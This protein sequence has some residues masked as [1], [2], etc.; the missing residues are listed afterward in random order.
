[1][2]LME[3]THHRSPMIPQAV[4]EAAGDVLCEYIAL[5]L[6]LAVGALVSSVALAAGMITESSEMSMIGGAMM[7]SFLFGFALAQMSN[8]KGAKE[9]GLRW[10]TN[11]C[12][13]GPTGLF[14]A[15]H[16]QSSF[17]EMPQW[18]VAMIFSGI[19]GPLAVLLIPIGIPFIRRMFQLYIADKEE[20][21][22][23]VLNHPENQ[24]ADTKTSSS[25]AEKGTA[26]PGDVGG[27]QGGK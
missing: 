5:K 18:V 26:S 17:Q 22:R 23:A 19:A 20:R 14:A 25:D 16:W 7:G 10:A 15:Y 27:S 24:N 4:K 8:P 12:L 2:K 13:G 9:L 11:F 3:W 6:N 21:L 1:M